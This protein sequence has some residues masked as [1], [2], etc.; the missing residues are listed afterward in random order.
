MLLGK[1]EA[2]I[3]IKTIK[4]R[5]LEI[6]NLNEFIDESET[7]ELQTSDIDTLLN[8]YS[9]FDK[10]IEDKNILTDEQ[11]LKIFKNRFGKEKNI[12]I[13]LQKYLNTYGEIIQ[14]YES[15]VENPEMTIQKIQSLLE[16]SR[17]SLYKE[18][19]NDL[20]TF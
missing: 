18:E 8:V 20:F 13:N 3:F 12:E 2:I 17:L 4:D 7:S 14:L 15:Y 19:K 16:E 9:F 6:R 5:N 10:L 1:E 11:F